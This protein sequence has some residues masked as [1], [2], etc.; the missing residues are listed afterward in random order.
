MFKDEPSFWSHSNG[1]HRNIVEYISCFT[2]IYEQIPNWDF[3]LLG[4][5]SKRRGDLLGEYE[6]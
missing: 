6:D 2:E 4:D 1:N 5:A 3:D